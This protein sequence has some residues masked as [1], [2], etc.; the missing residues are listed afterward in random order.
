MLT[1]KKVTVKQL[2]MLKFKQKLEEYEKQ[3]QIS[4]DVRKLALVP[5]LKDCR[6]FLLDDID[7][8]QKKLLKS[9]KSLQRV[10]PNYFQCYVK[11]SRVY[12]KVFDVPRPTM[13][14]RQE[15]IVLLERRL[16]MLKQNMKEVDERTKHFR[17][18]TVFSHDEYEYNRTRKTKS[19]YYT[20]L[21]TPY[22]S[23]G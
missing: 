9:L 22:T 15:D 6:I 14:D 12:I 7:A 11:D 2:Y 4:P 20:T 13:V 8:D 23:F 19:I 10:Y 5:G 1:F 18:G 16:Y 17:S 3:Q 21:N